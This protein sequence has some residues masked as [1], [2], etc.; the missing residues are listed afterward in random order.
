MNKR[1]HSYNDLLKE[2]QQLEIQLEVQKELIFQDFTALTNDLQPAL[3]V[4]SFLGKITTRDK[5]NVL[6]TGGINQLIDLLL[7]KVILAKKG[8]VARVVIPFFIKNYSS[9]LIAEHADEWMTKLF[10][11]MDRKNSNGQTASQS[12]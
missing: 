12:S 1:I 7:N 2:K 3:E 4:I 6:I 9:H 5:R 10:A 11:W 8:W